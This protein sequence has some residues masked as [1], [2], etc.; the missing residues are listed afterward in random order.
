M[1]RLFKVSAVI[2]ALTLCY[3][4]GSA[5]CYADQL[6]WQIPYVGLIN[7]NLNSTEA[8]LGYDAVL[9]QAIGG[10]SL[11]IWT[12]PKGI[13]ALQVGAVAPWPTNG[14]GVEPY[15]SAGHDIAKEIP[16]LN[17]YKSIHLN[18]FGRYS[19]STGKAGSGVSF[20]YSFAE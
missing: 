10:A 15:I 2:F 11:P 4:K 9:K 13:V 20:S 18:V 5:I 14:A 16:G 8:L 1:K 3:L 19:S 6:Q 12:D 17:Q 7:L